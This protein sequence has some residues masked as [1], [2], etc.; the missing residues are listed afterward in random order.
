MNQSKLVVIGIVLVVLIAGIKTALYTVDQRQ[1]AIVVQLGQVKRSDDEPGL[2]FKIPFIQTVYLFDSRI[3]TLDAAPQSYLTLEKKSL[4]VDSFVKWRIVDALKFYLTVGGSEAQ[5]RTLLQ[6]RINSGLRDQ[7][8]KRTLQDVVSGERTIIMQEVTKST[9]EAARDLGIEVVDVRLQRVDLPQE[10]SQSVYRRM[11]AER[12]RIAKEHRAKGAE[13]AEILRATAD[14]ERQI[15][16][17]E[18]YREAEKTRGEGDA[19]ATAVYA[20]A[21]NRNPGFY[22]FYR[23]LIAYQESFSKKD[24]IMKDDIM[25]VDPSADFFKYLKRPRAGQ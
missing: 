24:D 1:K 13:Q 23:S 6:Q 2:H 18:A 20:K 8:G 14:K 22:S 25:I 9:D 19:I 10:V 3:L 5:A 4:I 12:T 11:E 17:A 15:L 16:L 7:F 21:Y